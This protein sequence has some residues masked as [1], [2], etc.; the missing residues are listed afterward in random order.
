[1]LLGD[2]HSALQVAR[3]ENAIGP[4]DGT[5]NG[6]RTLQCGAQALGMADL[7]TPEWVEKKFD[8]DSKQGISVDKM[9][10]FL[11]PKFHSISDKSVEDFGV[12]ACDHYQQ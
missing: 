8:Y 10:G 2:C 5:V 4:A 11:K 7:G 12:I 6:T 3:P 9:L 1:M